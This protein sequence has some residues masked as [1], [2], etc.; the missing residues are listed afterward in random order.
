M[1][2]TRVSQTERETTRRDATLIECNNDIGHAITS[3][4][5]I[6]YTDGLPRKAV[7]KALLLQYYLGV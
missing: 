3:H 6:R 1:Y 5:N 2:L 4:S 7:V